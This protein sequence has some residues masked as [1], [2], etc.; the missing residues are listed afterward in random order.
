MTNLVGDRDAGEKGKKVAPSEGPPKGLGDA[1]VALLESEQAVL[2]LGQRTEVVRSQNLAL[3]DREVD[4]DLVEPAR[5]DRGVNQDEVG[6]AAAEALGG[7][8]ATVRGA[9]V[10]DPEDAAR[11]PVR[12]LCHDLCDQPLEGSNTG[13]GFATAEDLG[14]VDIPGGEV[15]PRAGALILVLDEHRAMRLGRKGEV[16]PEASL[17]AGFFVG[18]KHVIV[19]PQRRPCQWPW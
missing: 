5:M 17:D 19:R 16:D 13:L 14:A 12:L 4:L 18:R 1:L 6:P 9:V 8:G 3:D 11:P 2:E 15:S 10:D 7:F